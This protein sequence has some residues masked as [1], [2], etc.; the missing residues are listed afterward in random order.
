MSTVVCEGRIPHDEW[1][2]NRRN[3]PAIDDLTHKHVLEAA[4]GKPFVRML[5][6]DGRFM[7]RCAMSDEYSFLIE[8]EADG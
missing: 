8:C 2:A 3:L 1:V 4:E 5:Y 7:L 6:L